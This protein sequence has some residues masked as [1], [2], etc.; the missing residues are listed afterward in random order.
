MNKKI[1][2]LLVFFLSFCSKKNEKTQL[3]SYLKSLKHL[4]NTANTKELIKIYK[5]II[6]LAPGTKHSDDAI[7]KI[8]KNYYESGIYNKALKYYKL[9]LEVA[10]EL[11]NLAWKI[12]KIVAEIYYQKYKNYEKA[13]EYYIFAL[14][15]S[16]KPEELFFSSYYIGK[17]YF[18]LFNFEAAIKNLQKAYS[19]YKKDYISI[20]DY[21]ELLYYLAYTELLFIKETKDA[22][23]ASGFGYLDQSDIDS[24]L[25]HVEECIGI[26][27]DSKYGV[28]CKYLKTDV[29]LEN[30][31]KDEALE[32]LRKLRGIYP[33]QEALEYRIK[34]IEKENK[35]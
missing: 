6:A 8:A 12:N 21:Q 15:S 28:M 9:Y 27:P 31:L 17:T 23:T 35:I 22:Y 3:N 18:F 26:N 5:K 19:D 33:N 14:N 30:S 20:D 24:I 7:L 2:F 32:L 10:K 4:E 34:S 16:T 1:L 25:K 29:F 13:L 11:D